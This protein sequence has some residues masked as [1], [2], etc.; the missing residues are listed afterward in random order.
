MR[1]EYDSFTRFE[2]KPQGR[3]R[4]KNY[5]QGEGCLARLDELRLEENNM[6][7]SQAHGENGRVMTRRETVQLS[8]RRCDRLSKVWRWPKVALPGVRSRSLRHI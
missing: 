7:S 1:Y 8:G 3:H 5:W 4:V 2:S 6:S